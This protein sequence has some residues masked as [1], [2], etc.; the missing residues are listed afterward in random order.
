MLVRMLRS[1]SPALLVAVAWLVAPPEGLSGQ[2]GANVYTTA[3]DVQA[4][5]TQFDRHCS[6]C[7]GIGGTGGERG[8][9]LTRGFQRASTDA[10]LFGVV[11]DGVPD[12][13]MR[14]I[15]R[16]Q[17]DQTVWQIVAYLRSL[18]GGIRVDVPGDATAGMRVY[19]RVGC[20]ECH[21]IGGVGGL[22]GPDLSVVGSRRSPEELRSDLI[23]PDE[24]VDPDWWTMRVTHRD[25]TRVEGRRMGEGTYSVRILDSEGRMWSFQK[26][27][28]V[29]SER[30]ET[31]TMPSYRGRL[32]AMELQDLVAYLYGLTRSD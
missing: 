24:R 13:E 26:R 19:A 1:A 23:D 2:A 17:S 31:S 15:A 28:L 12:T 6:R 27:D 9:D 22:D 32:T 14:G 10:G 29:E 21:A 4:G 20:A 11:R 7:H 25:G 5:E 16:D 3:R 18:T 30:V 8:P